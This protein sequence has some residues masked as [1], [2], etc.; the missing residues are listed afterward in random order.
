[1]ADKFTLDDILDE[2]ASKKSQQSNDSTNKEEQVATPKEDEVKA[3]EAA[4]KQ[5]NVQAAEPVTEQI[6]KPEVIE[7]EVQPV[8]EK[9]P[10]QKAQESENAPK[11]TEHTTPLKKINSVRQAH[12]ER[13][14][15]EEE[16]A[17]RDAQKA[18]EAE[19][20][21]ESMRNAENAAI[22]DNLM[23]LKKE[24]GSV[25]KKQNVSPV[26]RPNVKDIDMG[27]TG[28]IIPKTEELDKAV[29]IPEDATFEQKTL[30]LHQHRK[31]KIDSFK[32]KTFDES[33]SKSSNKSSNSRQKEFEKYEEAP[34]ILRD[35]T[36]IK[37]NLTLRLCVL[38]FTGIF[39][40]VIAFANDFNWPMAKIF[41]RSLNPSA[42][43][44][45]NTILGIISIA[46][47]YTV[48]AEGVKNLF[49]RNADCDSVAAI[50][51]FI[52]IIS[53]II[54]LFNPESIR[55][56]FFHMYMSVSILGLM[57][58][59][60]GKLLIVKRT[61]KNFSYAAGEYDRYALRTIDN[62]DIASKFTKGSLNDF[63]ELSAMRKTEFVEDFMKNSYSSD[64]SDQFAKK[65]TPY[66]LIA[67]LFIALISLIFDKSASGFSEKMFV[68][69]AALSGTVSICSSV[70]LMLVVN[71]PL[72]K[73]AK[74]YLRY[75]AVMLGYSSVEEFADTNSILVD[76]QQLF[77]NGMVDFV[78]LKL[79]SSTMIEECI[80]MAAS[81]A[82]QADSVLKPTF[83]KML[84]GKTE[85]LYPV[86]SYI[87][88]DG[89][90]LS[91]W[92][93]NKRVLLGTRELMENHSIEG[94]PTLAKE[95][96]YGKGNI[97]LYLSISGVV[98]TLFVLKVNASLSVSRWLQ[99]LEAE[100][101]TTVIR[102]VDG[103][104]NINLL[105][106]LFNVSPTSLKLLPFRYHED[107]EHETEYQPRVSSSMLCSGHFPSFAML[108][109]GAKRLKVVSHLGVAMQ[110]GSLALGALMA[111]VMMLMGSFTQITASLFIIYQLIF[112]AFTL[113]IQSII[114]RP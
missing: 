110:F 55:D 68:M 72:S 97:V 27:L 30:L 74:K 41:D 69:L 8:A 82:C 92:I 101:I 18:M 87:Y 17:K 53:G 98:S 58:N 43:V 84:R 105:S 81:L 93:E 48:L 39:S 86:E 47:S 22:I 90:G 111:L 38:L 96:E 100:E 112:G 56:G 28:K 59:T 77:P 1:M 7:A 36:Q 50:G 71:I 63:P 14:K 32:L 6:D 73:A 94:I 52:S 102:S 4:P 80:L 34:R 109:I 108:I 57:F 76:A 5:E 75:S 107:Y 91:G 23:K 85:M 106:E 60:I 78:N 114:K 9:K 13:A 26:N 61:E 64:V 83:Y 37:N 66:I 29:E 65:T 70:V 15:E 40:V 3:A 2:Y 16:L 46:V 89:M 54:L 45:I 79:L 20:R 31:K 35:I 67:G 95:K 24:R 11:N 104:I 19:K 33:S 103:F 62:E 88:E 113:F 12:V 21:R 99:E 49:K 42:F 10:E 44:F 25:K 51:I